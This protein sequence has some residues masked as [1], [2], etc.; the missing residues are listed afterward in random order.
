[1]ERIVE[2]EEK[3]TEVEIEFE[4]EEEELEFIVPWEDEEM[5]D[6]SSGNKGL[7]SKT[8]GGFVAIAALLIVP[9]VTLPGMVI[10]VLFA[11]IYLI[12][13]TYAKVNQ[14]RKAKS[15]PSNGLRGRQDRADEIERKNPRTGPKDQFVK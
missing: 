12:D 14:I 5:E 15:T 4:E 9:L 13:W 6:S 7:Y 11:E 8:F 10:L 3:T 1:M 2:S